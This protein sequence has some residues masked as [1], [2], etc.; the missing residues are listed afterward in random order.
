MQLDSLVQLVASGNTRTVEEEWM[1]LIESPDVSLDE[2]SRYTAVL[3]ELKRCNR[4]PQA[5]AFAWAAVETLSARCSAAEVLPLAG[6]FLLE[7][8][9]SED[10]RGQVAELYRTVYAEEEG[11]AALLG[12]AGLTGGRPVRRALR[13]LDVCLAL[14]EGDF[15]TARDDDGAARI[16]EI[17]RRGWRF[18]IATG[19][20]SET[21]GAVELADRYE[22]SSVADFR[23]MRPTG[24]EKQ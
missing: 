14:G 23:V 22:P 17:D 4:T 15:L 16:D 3:G 13:T 7:I 10:L 9:E 18:T 21:L 1:Q 20:G 5:E 12:E 24:R 6:Q 2:L 8:G 19:S 11:L